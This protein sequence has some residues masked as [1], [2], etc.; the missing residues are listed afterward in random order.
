[1][2]NET[3]NVGITEQALKGRKMARAVIDN[4]QKFAVDW[5]EH[6]AKS[7][8]AKREFLKIVKRQSPV[9]MCILIDAAV[10]HGIRSKQFEFLDKLSGSVRQFRYGSRVDCL[11]Q[12]SLIVEIRYT[13]Q[14]KKQTG[15]NAQTVKVLD[16][17]GFPKVKSAIVAL[18]NY[19]YSDAVATASNPLPA[20]Q[21]GKPSASDKATP[22]ET[23]RNNVKHVAKLS[24]AQLKQKEN[25]TRASD[26][27]QLFSVFLQQHTSD[28]SE[29]LIGEL[30]ETFNAQLNK[31]RSKTRYQFGKL[32]VPAID[33]KPAT[34][35]TRA[36]KTA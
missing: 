35:V 22:I 5:C 7:S 2:K 20:Q 25:Q 9:N 26:I 23:V 34:R 30:V 18:A 15:H 11:V 8:Q 21:S 3:K 6:T 28:A 12:A 33:K 10:Q 31:S 24:P 36:R 29:K 1:M 4:A 16:A 32:A 13:Y 14:T 17:D 19:Q 27:K